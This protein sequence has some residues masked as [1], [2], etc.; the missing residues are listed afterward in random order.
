[1]RSIV[2]YGRLEAMPAL[3]NDMP[4]DRVNQLFMHPIQQDAFHSL[5]QLIAELR[6]CREYPD[7]NQFQQELLIKILDVQTHRGACTRVVKRLRSGKAVPADAPE[8]RVEEDVND[9]DSWE[10]EVAV[11]ERVDRQLRSIGDALAW[12]AFSY[13][14]RV[15]LALARNDPPGPMAG[16][17]GLE[18]ERDFVTQWSTDEKCFVLL[19]DITSCLRIGDATFFKSIGKDYEASLYEIKTDPNRRK[20]PQLRRQKLAEEAVRHGGPLPGDPT[21]R[22]ISLG[23]P[24]ETH[25]NMLRDGFEKAHHRGVLG[26]KVPGGTVLVATDLGK[27]YELWSEQEFIAKIG[28]VRS[29]ALKRAGILNF[30]QHLTYTSDDRVARSPIQPP[31]A[32]YPLPPEVCASLIV[33]MALFVVTISSEPLLDAL[34]TVGLSAEWVLPPD[35]NDLQSGQVILRAYKGN[36]GIE[37]CRSEI[38]RLLLELV[39]LSTWAEGVKELLTRDY[40]FDHPW[41]HFA[42][43][44]NVW[45]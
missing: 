2:H 20:P 11:C 7:Y 42:N 30:G 28:T 43:E 24:Y 13:D 14:R 10:L 33:D 41:P 45:A 3:L 25:L 8:L 5:V 34:R 27:A 18:A 38:Q 29:N 16:K 40:V 21:A 23:I 1:M 19:H 17:K 6:L 4:V 36:R 9:L 22:L 35:Q 32:I 39:D 44:R 12:R 37:M 15:I 26:M 31:W